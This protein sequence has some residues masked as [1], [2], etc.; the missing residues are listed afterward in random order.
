MERQQWLHTKGKDA[1]LQRWKGKTKEYLTYLNKLGYT[2][3][4]NHSNKD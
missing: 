3:K 4:I 2:A 1:L